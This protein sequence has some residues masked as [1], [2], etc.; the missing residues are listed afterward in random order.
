MVVLGTKSGS[1]QDNSSWSLPMQSS[2]VLEAHYV[3][4]DAFAHRLIK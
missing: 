1:N 4:V 2:N 3:H